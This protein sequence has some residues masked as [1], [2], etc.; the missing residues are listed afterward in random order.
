VEPTTDIFTLFRDLNVF[1][2]NKKRFSRAQG[3][4]RATL[5]VWVEP[6]K[7]P[8]ILLASLRASFQVE[9]SGLDEKGRGETQ[10]RASAK[11]AASDRGG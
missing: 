9:R 8:W 3:G 6:Q 2:R 10:L 1:K 5:R 7:N 4:R 11:L